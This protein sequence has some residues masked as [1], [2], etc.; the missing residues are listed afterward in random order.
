M[1]QTLDVISINIWDTLISLANLVVLFLIVKKF[2]YNP[3]K[4]ML[5]ARQNEIE[6]QY[7]N[8]ENAEKKA[9]ESREQ[10]EKILSGANAKSDEII[11][12]ATDTA[13]MRSETI[14]NEAKERAQGIVRQAEQEAI[15]ERKKA[16][17]G[18][19]KE[20]VEVSSALTSK[21]LEREIN[22]DDHRTLI[23]EFIEEIGESYE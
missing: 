4:N 2:L 15:L 12:N 22:K 10:W 13:K 11:K 23:D 18:I 17:D 16:T 6:S 20:I 19:K 14:V 5:K 3:V 21:L 9:N 8:A 1:V 7:N